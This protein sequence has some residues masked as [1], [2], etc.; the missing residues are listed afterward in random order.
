MFDPKCHELAEA[1]LED[2]AGL[3]TK[4][5]VNDLAQTIQTAIENWI[6]EGRMASEP[7]EEEDC[8]D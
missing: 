4:R 5:H 8:S 6:E 7:R 2:E 1:F 3:N